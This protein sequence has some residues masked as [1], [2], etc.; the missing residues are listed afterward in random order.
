MDDGVPVNMAQRVLGHEHASTTLQLYTRRTLDH[1]RILKA[2]DD[3]DDDGL[4]QPV[5]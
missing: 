4:C 2:L 1:Q 3:D 5:R